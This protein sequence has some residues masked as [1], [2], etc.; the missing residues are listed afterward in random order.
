[1]NDPSPEPHLLAVYQHQHHSAATLQEELQ[2]KQVLPPKNTG[3]LFNAEILPDAT[4]V[5]EVVS[6]FASSWFTLH[7]C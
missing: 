4:T 5:G 7:D 2:Q 6:A 1:M 3:M